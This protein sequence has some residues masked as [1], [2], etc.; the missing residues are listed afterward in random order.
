MC[1]AADEYNGPCS[2]ELYVSELTS[3]DKAKIEVRCDLCSNL[4][5]FQLEFDAIVLN[6]CGVCW[7]CGSAGASG[8]NGDQDASAVC[9]LLA[10]VD[11]TPRALL[12]CST[13]MAPLIL[14]AAEWFQHRAFA[15]SFMFMHP[16]VQSPDMLCS[17]VMYCSTVLATWQ[18]QVGEAQRFA[19]SIRSPSVQHEVDLCCSSLPW[20]W[21][22]CGKRIIQ[23]D[24]CAWKC[25]PSNL[26]SAFQ[27]KR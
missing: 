16:S 7:P 19:H 14:Q 1:Q 17:F 21:P 6:R 24:E 9:C 27:W 3:Q 2:T 11:A 10:R 26:L 5:P 25:G 12:P 22:I 18:S 8:Q 4:V 23:H 20:A 13:R 15:A